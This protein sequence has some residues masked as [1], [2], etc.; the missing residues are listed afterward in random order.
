MDDVL[1]SSRHHTHVS[2]ISHAS[3]ISGFERELLFSLLHVR[4]N[5]GLALHHSVKEFVS[6]F[7]EVALFISKSASRGM[8]APEGPISPAMSRVGQEQCCWFASR[9]LACSASAKSL[10]QS[11]LP[12]LSSH[13][14]RI[15]GTFFSKIDLALQTPAATHLAPPRF[16]SAC[17]PADRATWVSAASRDLWQ[18]PEC[19]ISVRVWG[20]HAMGSLPPFAPQF[21]SQAWISMVEDD[22]QVLPVSGFSASASAAPSTLAASA[23]P[24]ALPVSASTTPAGV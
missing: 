3:W 17:S 9:Y 15:L 14:S 4:S 22:A 8:W 12:W 24:A 10:L 1:G 6:A 13:M 7:G 23:T 20:T 19:T 11:L 21:L 18:V 2:Q 16:S 5:L